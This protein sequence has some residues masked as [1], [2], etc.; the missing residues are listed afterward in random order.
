MKILISPNAFKG[1]IEAD[2]AA[3]IIRGAIMGVYPNAETAVLPIADGGDGTCYLLGKALGL[4]SEEIWVLNALGRSVK[5]Y[6]FYDTNS[7]TAYLDV[8]TV[9]GIKHLQTAERNPWVAST[10]GTGQLIQAAIKAGANHIVLGLGGSATV[11]LGIGILA[12][13]GFGFLNEKGRETPL[14]SDT[15]LDKI[16]HIQRPVHSLDIRFT[17]LCDVNHTFWGSKGAIPVFGPQKGLSPYEIPNLE[18]TCEGVLA[19]LSQKAKKEVLDQKGFG[20]AGGI[21][22]GLSFFFD[23]EIQMG[24]QW[25]FEKVGM[26]EK[27][28]WADLVITGEGKY[29]HQSAGGKGSYELLQLCKQADKPCY[30]ITAG[31]D[32]EG[33]GFKK[34]LVLPDLD[35]S[36]ADFRH[37]AKEN[38]RKSIVEL[39]TDE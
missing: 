14:F 30:L 33:S 3:E 31:D 24:A 29:D 34:V 10:Y 5:G 11:D 13:L 22:Y 16:N 9:S 28:K 27:V 32:F 7:K 1:T 12:A 26:E 4:E 19:L 36:S 39:S 17:C 23:T 35:F 25:F 8:S 37:K 20:A 2:E 21:A 6:F 38:L 15:F 18:K